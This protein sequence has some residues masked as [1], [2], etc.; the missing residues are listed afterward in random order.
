M[1]F[2]SPSQNGPAAANDGSAK[3]NA[4]PR[5]RTRERF[6][7]SFISVTTTRGVGDVTTTRGSAG[8]TEAEN[9][10]A[11]L[12]AGVSRQRC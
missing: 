5:Y 9:R 7:V 8:L 4:T 11:G 6:I 3:V 2:M 1:H 10:G 12:R